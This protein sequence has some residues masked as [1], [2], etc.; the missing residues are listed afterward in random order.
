MD[1]SEM[2]ITGLPFDV[3][4]EKAIIGC[5]LARPE[6][7]NT[8]LDYIKPESFYV[9]NHQK[10]FGIMVRN[11]TLGRSIDIITV[12][13][14]AVKE[15]VFENSSEAKVRLAD[16]VR[17]EMILPKNLENYCRIVEEKF[18]I[19]QLILASREIMQ[20]ASDEQGTASELIEFAEQKIYDIRQGKSANRLTLIGNA[21]V[22]VFDDL[23]KRSGPDR[24]LYLGI[25]SGYNDLDSLIYG[26]KKSDLLILAARPAMGKSTLAMNI[27]VNVARRSDNPEVAVF[28]LEMSTEQLVTRMLSAESLVENKK[29]M[30][31]DISPELWNKISL[32]A[33]RLNMMKIYIDDTP[34]MSVMQMKSR[35]RRMKNLGLVIV[36]HIQLMSAGRRIDNR[37]NEMS[38]ITRQLK[39]MAKEMDVPVI[40][41]SQLSRSVDSR[42][43]KRPVLSDLRDS[44]SIEQDAD[45]VM[46]LYRDEYY[47]KENPDTS[48]E[49]IIAKNRHGETG[50]IK[51][52]FNSQYTLFV[53]LDK[54]G[55]PPD[56]G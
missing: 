43:D 29:L 6:D 34:G 24:D 21:L 14:E 36:D 3:E 33:D 23:G 22:D 5:I 17:D 46:F 10:L 30:R 16:L 55:S 44:G 20:A 18:Y 12:I 2:D 8:A 40:A 39:I 15:K 51:L 42:T 38:E 32:G 45:I 53:G 27:A 48:S 31:G 11:F 13:D 4:A 19:R 9:E 25:K 37:V 26:L 1:L 41:L 35:L 28:S 56:N 54:Y 47:N 50:T 7:I 52:Q 49:C